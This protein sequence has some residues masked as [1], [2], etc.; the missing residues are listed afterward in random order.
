M[1]FRNLFISSGYELTIKNNQLTIGT[2]DLTFPLEDINSIVV[3]NA[4]VTLSAGLLQRLA[5]NEVAV[6]FCDEKH[7]PSAVLLPIVKHSRHFKLLKEQIDCSKPLY[8]QFW[9]SIVEKKV[10]NQAKCLE[11]LNIPGAMTLYEMAK[12]IRS[13]DTT[14]VEAKAAAF[15]F[16]RVFGESFHRSDE[17]YTNALLDYGY[18]VIRGLIARTIV[19]YGFEPSIGIWH[20][21]ELNS[22]NLA[23]DLIEPYRPLVDLYVASFFSDES[24]EISSYDR[25]LMVRMMNYD[26]K[27][28]GQKRILKNCIDITVSSLTSSLSHSKNQL[29]LPDLFGLSEHLYE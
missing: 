23:D 9:Q 22:F 13:G 6:Y 5:N 21:N 16:K 17:S 15:Y 8:K 1:Q 14:N 2:E 12:E 26:M 3:E 20:K 11:L 7:L 4:R 24:T 18:A 19:A 25:K 29:K 10:Q 27:I 28:E